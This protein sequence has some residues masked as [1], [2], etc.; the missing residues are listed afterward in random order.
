VVC[1][2]KVIKGKSHGLRSRASSVKMLLFVICKKFISIFLENPLSVTPV[3]LYFYQ[4]Q[5]DKGEFKRICG[6]FI[7]YVQ[8]NL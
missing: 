4:M 5:Y 8:Y 7:S 6:S 3:L 2:K 1:V